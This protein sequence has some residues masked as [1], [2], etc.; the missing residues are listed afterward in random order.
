MCTLLFLALMILEEV[1]KHDIQWQFYLKQCFKVIL[2][3]LAKVNKY[4]HWKIYV[5]YHFKKKSIWDLVPMAR[6]RFILFFY[7]I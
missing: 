2:L 4:H 1:I 6:A 7:N 3:V 5:S